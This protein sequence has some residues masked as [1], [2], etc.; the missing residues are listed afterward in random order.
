MCWAVKLGQRV[1]VA[2]NAGP[3]DDLGGSNV[4]SAATDAELCDIEFAGDAGVGSVE[5]DPV[6]WLAI[7][8]VVCGSTGQVNE[9]LSLLAAS[10]VLV[11]G[12]R[13]AGGIGAGG[14]GAGQ[15]SVGGMVA[16]GDRGVSGVTSEGTELAD[17]DAGFCAGGERRNQASKSSH[18][19]RSSA[20]ERHNGAG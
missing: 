6:R 7:R 8:Q 13:R 18:S 2:V 3:N 15:S 4:L 11:V 12:R 1:T 9:S 20:S 10:A 17:A 14:I 16:L 5:L 19:W